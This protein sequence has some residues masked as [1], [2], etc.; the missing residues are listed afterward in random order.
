MRTR[1]LFCKL[2]KK[3]PKE[4]AEF[5]D[6][7]GLQFGRAKDEIKTILLCLDFDETVL[8]FIIKNNL[9]SKIDVVITHHPFFFNPKMTA[10]KKNPYKLPVFNKMEELNIP[11]YSFHTNFDKA[12]EGMN[13]ALCEKLEL[14][15]VRRLQSDDCARG[16]D[17]KSPMDINEFSKYAIE[18]LN[19]PYASL[20]NSGKKVIN[21]VAIVGG[22]GWRSYKAAQNE[23]YDIFI[24]GDIPHNGRRDIVNDKYNFLN[25]PH[26]VENAFME[27]FKKVL[28]EIEPSLEVITFEH[29]VPPT[30]IV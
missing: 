15:N 1:S 2:G 17:L 13:I 19:L 14:E 4:S 7:V 16:G 29:E 24:S 23:G 20:I 5:Y 3:F 27:Q 22:G 9:E 18:K 25:V 12:D 26:E 21:N 30:L 11:I 6:R 10:L 28:L 8:D